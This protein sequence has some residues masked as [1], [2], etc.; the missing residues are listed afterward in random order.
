MTSVSQ[1][2]VHVS[3][4]E[5]GDRCTREE[6]ERRREEFSTSFAFFSVDAK[7]KVTSHPDWTTDSRHRS[8][9]KKTASKKKTHAKKRSEKKKEAHESGNG[10]LS[11]PFNEGDD[12]DWWLELLHEHRFDSI[13]ASKK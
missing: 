3:P 6:G 12:E 10:V 2:K 4:A 7:E 13:S 8:A 11:V 1:I 9:A 5:E